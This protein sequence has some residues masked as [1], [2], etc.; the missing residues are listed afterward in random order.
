MRIVFTLCL[1]VACVFLAGCEEY[2]E[3]DR[4]ANQSLVEIG[5]QSLERAEE[6]EDDGRRA[7]A[8]VQ[9]KRSLWAFRYHEQLT[10][11]EPFLLDDALD[12]VA[13][14]GRR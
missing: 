13:R 2:T 11:E 8:N 6:L 9:Y 5:E 1:F 12:G 14:T 4:G 3:P 7:E 10:G